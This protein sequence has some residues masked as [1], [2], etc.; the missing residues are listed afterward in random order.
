MDQSQKRYILDNID[1]KPIERIAV[2]LNIKERKI[3]KFIE[4]HKTKKQETSPD[5]EK[6]IW[7]LFTFGTYCGSRTYLGYNGSI[8]IDGSGG[9][10]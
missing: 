6:N 10:E 3:R 9:L 1:K 4:R 2:E 7:G 5:K 8:Y